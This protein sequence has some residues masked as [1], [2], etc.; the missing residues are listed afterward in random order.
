MLSSTQV[1]VLDLTNTKVTSTTELEKAF[2]TLN[3]CPENTEEY[4]MTEEIPQQK[5]APRKS[6]SDSESLD[7]KTDP[8]LHT[9]AKERIYGTIR[10]L[11]TA[12]QIAL[13]HTTAQTNLTV[14][15]GPAPY[16]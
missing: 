14:E 12:T 16:T 13:T 4:S 3:L 5:N 1:P 6:I 10:G 2:H 9:S 11:A 8:R 7:E 15:R